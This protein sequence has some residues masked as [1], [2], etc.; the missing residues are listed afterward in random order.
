[1]HK[2]TKKLQTAVLNPRQYSSNNTNTNNI[3]LNSLC[4]F[5]TEISHIIGRKISHGFCFRLPFLGN[6]NHANLIYSIS[7]HSCHVRFASKHIICYP[8]H[9]TT[10][11]STHCICSPS[12]EPVRCY[13][14]SIA[15]CYWLRTDSV[16]LLVNIFASFIDILLSDGI[17][18][19]MLCQL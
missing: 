5:I 12:R 19:S 8:A 18:I 13:P 1:M 2:Y 6:F 14:L 16:S 7:K 4:I 15:N 9:G 10:F 17:R 11:F 3:C